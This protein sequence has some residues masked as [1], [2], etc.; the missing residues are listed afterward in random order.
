MIKTVSVAPMMDCTDKH[1]IYFLSLISKNIHLYTEMI[2]ANAIIRGDRRKLLSF[3]K[4]SN[5]VT[6]QVGGSNPNDLAEVCKISEDYGYKEINLNLGCPSKK[7]QKNKFGACL[8]QEPNLVARCIEAMA[9][10]TKLP[11]TIKTRIGYNDVE[12]FYFLKSFIQTIKDAGSQKFIIHARKALLKKLSP[13]EN[14][15]IPPLKYDFVYKLKDYFKNDEIIINGGIK[16]TN[17]IKNHLKKVDG[18]MIGRAIYH[19][20]YFLADIEKKVFG[21]DNVPTRSDIMEN[22]IPYIQ[23]ETSKGTQLNHIM[24]HTVGLF[25]GQNGSKVWKQYL[26]KNMCIRD[27]DL[28]KVNHI[29]DQVKKTSPVFLER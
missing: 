29:M 14:L 12:N 1:E 20:P 2:V 19:S 13:K 24:R 11:I 16:T 8:M 23:E 22:L 6:L 28:Q 4:I 9:K 10:A 21:N 7:V 15:N 25:H 26:S 27:A 3:K 17:E 18:V 5:P